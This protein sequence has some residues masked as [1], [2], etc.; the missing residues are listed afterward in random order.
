[1]GGLLHC[2]NG[3]APV[4]AGANRMFSFGFIY[5]LRDLR[6]YAG[7]GTRSRARNVAGGLARSRGHP[8]APDTEGLGATISYYSGAQPSRC[9]GMLVSADPHR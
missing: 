8:A 2:A 4:S 1:M 5:K 3:A 6:F 7:L 9:S